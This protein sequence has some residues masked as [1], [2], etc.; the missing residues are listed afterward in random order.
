[1]MAIYATELS[2]VNI[3]QLSSEDA[4]NS[5]IVFIPHVWFISNTGTVSGFPG[6]TVGENHLIGPQFVS[7]SV[8]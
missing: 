2:S 6:A 1:M 5:P 3:Y 7:C 4:E 8:L